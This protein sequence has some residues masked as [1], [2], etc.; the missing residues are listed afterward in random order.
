MSTPRVTI[1]T[2]TPVVSETFY[3]LFDA[4]RAATTSFKEL[5]RVANAKKLWRF[6][7]YQRRRARKPWLYSK[8]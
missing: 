3:A 8:P 7:S 4:A 5:T 2:S 6:N 1:C